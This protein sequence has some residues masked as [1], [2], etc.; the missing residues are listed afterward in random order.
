MF[1]TKHVMEVDY[2]STNMRG[3]NDNISSQA[4]KVPSYIEILKYILNILHIVIYCNYVVTLLM[5]SAIIHI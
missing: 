5:Y 3:N 4:V 2:V 1:L